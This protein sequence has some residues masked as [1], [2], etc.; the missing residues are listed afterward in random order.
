MLNAFIVQQ[1]QCLLAG[2]FFPYPSLFNWPPFCRIVNWRS[3]P[4]EDFYLELEVP[5]AKKTE[6]E[7][8]RLQDFGLYLLMTVLDVVNIVMK[9]S[10]MYSLDFKV[11]FTIGFYF[12]NF[13]WA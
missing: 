6:N 3:K 1:V 2:P 5:E 9:Y 8:E 4:P 7:T 11:C 12:N 13:F 10:K